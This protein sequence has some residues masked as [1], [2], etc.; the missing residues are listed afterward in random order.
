M[1]TLIFGAIL[2][3]SVKHFSSNFIVGKKFVIRGASTKEGRLWRHFFRYANIR[4]RTSTFISPGR[5]D[6][7]SARNAS[8]PKLHGN[9]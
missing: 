3:H 7:R 5:E 2:N 9:R 8:G 6:K 4:S 1:S